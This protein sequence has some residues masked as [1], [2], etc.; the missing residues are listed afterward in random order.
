[1]NSGPFVDP[2]HARVEARSEAQ[3]D[4]LHA[5]PD[6][7]RADAL[8]DSDGRHPLEALEAE[9]NHGRRRNSAQDQEERSRHHPGLHQIQASV[10]TSNEKLYNI[11]MLMSLHFRCREGNWSRLCRCTWL[12]KRLWW[13]KSRISSRASSWRRRRTVGRSQSATCV[14]TFTTLLWTICLLSTSP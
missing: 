10:E 8:R 4:R 2:N 13:R 11:I 1:M 9:A 5:D 7:V 6:R 3:E 14:S 12:L